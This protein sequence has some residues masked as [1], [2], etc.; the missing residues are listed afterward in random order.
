MTD[1][2]TSCGTPTTTGAPAA[3]AIPSTSAPG[4]VA[5]AS[6]ITERQTLDRWP[7]SLNVRVV[8]PAPAVVKTEG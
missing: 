4:H 8:V 3:P 6:Q 7:F 2:L 5:T 1:A